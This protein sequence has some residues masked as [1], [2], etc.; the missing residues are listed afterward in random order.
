MAYEIEQRSCNATS[1]ASFA[2]TPL[3]P[4]QI[5]LLQYQTG[6]TQDHLR[7][8]VETFERDEAPS[9]KALSYEWGDPTFEHSITLNKK[10]FLVRSNL[11]SALQRLQEH[12]SGFVWIDALYIDQSNTGERNHRVKSMGFV[13]RNTR[14]VIAWLGAYDDS[15]RGCFTCAE[16]RMELTEG[17]KFVTERSSGSGSGKCSPSRGNC[18]SP[19]GHLSCPLTISNSTRATILRTGLIERMQFAPRSAALVRIRSADSFWKLQMWRAGRQGL[20]TPQRHLH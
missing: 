5:R 14:V 13:Y 2:H 9:Y 4:S 10:T 15:I 20:R 16:S 12:V 11:R 1:A 19:V 7:L 17:F 8:S 3:Q 18:C 6:S